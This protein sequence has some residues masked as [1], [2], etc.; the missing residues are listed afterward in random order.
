MKNDRGKKVPKLKIKLERHVPPARK[1]ATKRPRKRESSGSQRN[2]QDCEGKLEDE[3]VE[4]I[5]ATKVGRKLRT[6]TAA[7]SRLKPKETL[8]KSRKDTG[9]VLEQPLEPPAKKEKR[10][11]VALPA[12]KRHK[13]TVVFLSYVS[14]FRI[15][16]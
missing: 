1:P 10:E 8:S 15:C 12:K 9:L 5:T 7:R 3:L 11:T 6:K 4:P 13:V 16:L 2:M 14:C